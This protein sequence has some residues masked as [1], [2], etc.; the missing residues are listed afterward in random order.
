LSPPLV[1]NAAE[2]EKSAEIISSVINRAQHLNPEFNTNINATF[3]L[4]TTGTNYESQY[5]IN[6]RSNKLKALGLN[7]HINDSTGPSTHLLQQGEP[8]NPFQQIQTAE[9]TQQT[10]QSESS[11]TDFTHVENPFA[12]SASNVLGL[13]LGETPIVDDK[14]NE[15]IFESEMNKRI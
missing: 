11:P 7:I 2:I 14:D 13:Q 15:I 4:P 6:R 12:M 10:Q 9:P 8:L 3:N 1:I 5:I